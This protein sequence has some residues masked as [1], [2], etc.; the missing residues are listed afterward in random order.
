MNLPEISATSWIWHKT[1]YNW[2]KIDMDSDV[3]S[4]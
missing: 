1:I 4:Y 3:S 2:I